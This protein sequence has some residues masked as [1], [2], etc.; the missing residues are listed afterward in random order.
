MKDNH[1]GGLKY[2]MV[3]EDRNIG[4][5]P[6]SKKGQWKEVDKSDKRCNLGRQ[7]VVFLSQVKVILLFRVDR[8]RGERAG[9][10]FFIYVYII[11][12]YIHMYT[13]I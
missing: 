6:S 5:Q 1:G 12:I 7:K 13:H 9:L 2:F 4:T 8:T 3:E 10:N 11:Y